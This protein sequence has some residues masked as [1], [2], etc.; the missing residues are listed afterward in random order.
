MSRLGPA[1]L[2]AL[3][4]ALACA[5]PSAS[6]GGRAPPRTVTGPPLRASGAPVRIA[7]PAPAR[8]TTRPAVIAKGR[9]PDDGRDELY[10]PEPR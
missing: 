10:V 4:L 8:P 9:I 2:L 6:G 1:A 3:P 5:G 7:L